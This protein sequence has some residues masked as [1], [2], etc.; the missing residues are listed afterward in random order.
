VRNNSQ[1]QSLTL[2]AQFIGS[3]LVVQNASALTTLSTMSLNTIEVVVLQHVPLLNLWGEP[4]STLLDQL[5]VEDTLLTTISLLHVET[6]Q[7]IQVTNNPN[8]TDIDFRAVK[9]VTN[10]FTV[11]V[12]YPY[13]SVRLDGLQ[14]A[15]NISWR[16]IG[17]AEVPN[18][19]KVNG[20]L[21][22]SDSSVHTVELPKLAYAGGLSFQNNENLTYIGAPDLNSVGDGSLTI[23]NNSKLASPGN[24]SALEKV[25]GIE[26]SGDFTE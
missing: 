4:N 15:N 2:D 24:F 11:R 8:L 21:E 9:N 6:M 23:V 13:L 14:W 10:Y 26:L 7:E 19:D 25:G 5:F 20:S 12:N 17:D 16:D 1:L 3:S 22:I 18:L